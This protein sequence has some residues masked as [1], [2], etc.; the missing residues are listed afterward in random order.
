MES[1]NPY[2]T[3]FQRVI[4]ACLVIGIVALIGCSGGNNSSGSTS[5]GGQGG[6]VDQTPP[7]IT[8]PQN[9][10]VSATNVNGIQKT[11]LAIA[12]FLSAASAMDNV[13]GTI[14]VT[15]NAPSVFPV[16]YDW[17]SF[18]AVDTAGNNTTAT[19]LIHVLSPGTVVY[20]GTV[21]DEVGI[22][23]SGAIPF[24]ETNRGGGWA[25]V[26][27]DSNGNFSMQFNA[28]AFPN[29]IYFIVGVRDIPAKKLR[30][31]WYNNITFSTS[32]KK[33][34]THIPIQQ[35]PT[36]ISAQL[37]L[38]TGALIHVATNT[39]TAS[40]A[41]VKIYN[42]FSFHQKTVQAAGAN[43]TDFVVPAG[44][45]TVKYEPSWSASGRADTVYW[46]GTGQTFDPAL[47]L[48]VTAAIAQTQ[49][50]SFSDQLMTS[51]EVSAIATHRINY[52]R[53]L[54]GLT[55]LTDNA[56]LAQTARNHSNY[57]Q[58]NQNNPSILGLGAHTETVGFPGFTGV[59]A[60]DRY[61]FVSGVMPT[62][63]WVGDLFY[64]GSNL[65]L[66]VDW[67]I[68]SV[69]HQ[70]PLLNSHTALIGT[71]RANGG[72]TVINTGTT[73]STAPHPLYVYPANGQLEV[74]RAFYNGEMPDPLS[75]SGLT[76][77]TGPVISMNAPGHSIIVAGASITETAS[78]QN[79]PLLI[80]DAASDPNARLTTERVFFFPH[81]VLKPQTSYTVNVVYTMDGVIRNHV[82]SFTTGWE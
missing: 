6:F 42:H 33:N 5:T 7:V 55:L 36:N 20:S 70:I 13:D 57:L 41:T 50:V 56:A 77:P 25:G 47:A 44:S 78:G 30:G 2:Q 71:G 65:L 43:I 26:A 1:V 64:T 8:L 28:A 79:I 53:R 61:A 80:I 24:V 62:T 12:T 17:V 9:I 67:F 73:I 69:Y 11:N 16:G 3:I 23:V 35:P 59:S 39:A 75:G 32:L 51:T 68:N 38:K 46:G 82:W 34:A 66:A 19:A 29:E 60:Q 37:V 54:L 74:P 18:T 21:V 27:S 58:L 45:Y 63:W 22:P 76:A 72:W 10:T 14:V 40:A 15:N 81:Q 31:A 4:H 49:S 52:Y 48:P